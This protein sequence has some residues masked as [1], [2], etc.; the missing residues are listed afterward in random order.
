MRYFLKIRIIYIAIL[1]V[2][3]LVTLVQIQTVDAEELAEMKATCGDSQDCLIKAYEKKINDMN[4]EISRIASFGSYKPNYVLIY[5]ENP[6]AEDKKIPS[7]DAD[8]KFQFS[9]KKELGTFDSGVF[10]LGYTQK[11]FW[12]MYDVEDS[13]PFRESNYNPELF[14]RLADITVGDT[15]YRGDIGFEH[16]SNGN[17]EPLS[18]SWNR[19]YVKPGVLFNLSDDSS[20]GLALKIWYRFPEP[21]K[22]N[23]DDTRGDENPDI[24]KYYGNSELYI[25]LSYTDVLL[26]LMGRHNFE[27]KRGAFQLDLSFP[28]YFFDN[29]Y[30]HFQYWE[31]YGES[32]LYYNQ[33]INRYGF[34]FM[35]AR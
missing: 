4:R 2:F 29:V 31:G 22:E 21:E 9:I 8:V 11:S 18:R 12:R 30:W 33:K 26:S 3:C 28:S 5:T 16:E 23:P 24:E 13:R 25:D 6:D 7:S 32:L 1:S 14:F 17:K 19:S 15:V 27:E 20:L 10:Y 35:F 34:G